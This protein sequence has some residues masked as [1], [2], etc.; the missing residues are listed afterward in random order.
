MK[1]SGIEINGLTADSRLVASGYLFAALDSE[2]A[3]G[4]AYIPNAIENGAS[5]ILGKPEYA[6]FVKN[7]PF[8]AA[9]NPSKKFA[10]LASEFYGEHPAHIAAITGT[11]GKTSI[12]DFVR[13]ILI[14]MGEKAA[15]MGTLGLI[16]DDDAPIPS[17]NTTPNAVVMAQELSELKNEGYDY[18]CMETS[19]HGLCQY[20]VGGVKVEVAG[21]TNLTRDHLDYHKTFENYLEAKLIL[22]R[23]ILQENGVA[24]LNADIDVYPIIRQACIKS[25][26]KVITYGRKGEELRLLD[27][28]AEN[29]GQRIRM[30]YFGIEKEI[31][32]PLAGEFQVMNVLCALG[33][34]TALTHNPEEVIKHVHKIKGAKGR[35][36]LVGMTKNGA[37][38]YIDYAHTP[39]ALENVLRSMRVHTKNKLHVLFGCGGDRDAGKRPIMGKIANDLADVVYVTDD[40]P[41][42]ENAD[43]IREQ[44]MVSCS[45]GQNIE[46]RSRAIK[47]AISK[48]QKGD[49]L[50][51]AGKGHETGQYINGKIY[52][53]SDYDEVCKNL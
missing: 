29:N 7:I 12:A 9:E 40:N 31:F 22:F 47:F 41:R 18:V 48:L 50:V 10:E 45:K 21:F 46:N 17:P 43:N 16:K 1:V 38:I 52:P 2:K 20:R 35:L 32:I 14:S 4:S 39:D 49:V 33:M 13:Q 3:L 27:A 23:E 11:N 8:I 42:T 15:S 28:I 19:S 24:V 36:D 51:L 34:V 26:K 25:G 6:K 5:V 44:I 37:S 53:F 30:L